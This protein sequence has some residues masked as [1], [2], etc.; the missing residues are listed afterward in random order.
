MGRALLLFLQLVV[1]CVLVHTEALPRSLARISSQNI[2]TLKVG[3]PSSHD[4]VL[5]G[6]AGGSKG[7]CTDFVCQELTPQAVGQVIA[8][9]D[10]FTMRS[11]ASASQALASCIPFIVT[12]FVS[13]AYCS[14]MLPGRS[15]SGRSQISALLLSRVQWKF[16]RLSG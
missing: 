10:S 9:C 12:L 8:T 14:R 2:A 7:N 1:V 16:R 13:A 15:E 5:F 4:L 3:Q 11:P 6:G